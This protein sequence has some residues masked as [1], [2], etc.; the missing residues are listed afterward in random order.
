MALTYT[1][2]D[3]QTPWKRREPC[4]PSSSSLLGRELPDHLTRFALLN[5][6][7]DPSPRPS[8]LWKGRRRIVARLLAIQGYPSDGAHWFPVSDALCPAFKV[9]TSGKTDFL[10]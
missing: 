6:K 5:L 1:A 4:S 8:P 10:S 3:R 7:S 9:A 2:S